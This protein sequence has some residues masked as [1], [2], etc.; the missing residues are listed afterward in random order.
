MNCE[1]H[2]ELAAGGT[3]YEKI[4]NL[5]HLTGIKP[6]FAIRLSHLRKMGLQSNRQTPNNWELT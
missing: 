1:F 2:N 3:G 6:A 5:S 4:R